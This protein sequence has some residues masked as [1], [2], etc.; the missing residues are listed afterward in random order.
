MGY[1]SFRE[2]LALVID[3]MFIYKYDFKPQLENM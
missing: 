2:L 3:M 1:I